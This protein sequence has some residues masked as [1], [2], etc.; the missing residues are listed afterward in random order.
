MS[1]KEDFPVLAAVFVPPPEISGSKAKKLMNKYLSARL[2][3]TMRTVV[4]QATPDNRRRLQELG[5]ENVARARVRKSFQDQ[6]GL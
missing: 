2:M 3:R 4:E 1:R 5:P 6:V